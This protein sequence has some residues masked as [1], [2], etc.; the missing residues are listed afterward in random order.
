MIST[1]V[2]Y[3][4]EAQCATTD[5]PWSTLRCSFQHAHYRLNN[6]AREESLGGCLWYCICSKGIMSLLSSWILVYID[7][8]VVK[9]LL[10]GLIRMKNCIPYHTIPYSLYSCVH[11]LGGV[12]DLQADSCLVLRVYRSIAIQ[13]STNMI[14]LLSDAIIL[15]HAF[16]HLC[17][18]CSLIARSKVR[19]HFPDHPLSQ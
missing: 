12:C 13:T 4:Y 2:L 19:K 1:T 18:V 16:T 15:H 6:S 8:E 9:R 7:L 14:I 11:Q 3:L 5:M 17:F 10:I